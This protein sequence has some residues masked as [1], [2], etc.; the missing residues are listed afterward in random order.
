MPWHFIFQ[1]PC[2]RFPAVDTASLRTTTSRHPIE[3][4][5]LNRSLLPDL[6]LQS[7]LDC[8]YRILADGI[9]MKSRRQRVPFVSDMLNAI[10]GDEGAWIHSNQHTRKRNPS[11]K[12]C[13]RRFGG[14]RRWSC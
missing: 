3:T 13:I 8:R 4:W 1:P 2:C 11:P 5:S 7:T 14:H 9:D 10:N 6:N 12:L